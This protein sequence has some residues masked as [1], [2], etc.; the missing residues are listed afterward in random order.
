MTEIGDDFVESESDQLIILAH[1]QDLLFMD[2]PSALIG[3]DG[4]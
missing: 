2:P 4:N 1:L 3:S